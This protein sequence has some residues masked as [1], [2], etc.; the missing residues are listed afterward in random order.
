MNKWKER[1]AQEDVECLKHPFTMIVAG[2]TKVGKTEWTKRMI[3]CATQLIRPVPDRIVWCYTEWQPGYEELADHVEFSEGLPN[4]DELKSTPGQRKLVV[5]DDF[6]DSLKKDDRLTRL[7]TRGS[8]HWNMSVVHICQ[9]L[10]F[11][12]L[13][14]ARINSHYLVLMKSPADRLQIANLARQMY[15]GNT[16]HFLSAYNDAVSSSK[17]GYLFV[18]CTPDT[19]DK[20]R[21]RTNVFPGQF[22]TVYMDE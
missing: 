7:F 11:G 8:H 12:G 17:Y 13:R 18:D 20:Y 10:F 22:L 19:D 6:M 15:P 16:R 1:D 9:A 3:K 2:P 21:L 5:L 14:T 4:L